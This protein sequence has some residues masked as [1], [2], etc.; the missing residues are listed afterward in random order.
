MVFNEVRSIAG[1]IMYGVLYCVLYSRSFF[2][3]D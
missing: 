1:R 2:L 3:K